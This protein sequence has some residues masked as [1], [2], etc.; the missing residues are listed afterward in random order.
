MLIIPKKVAGHPTPILLYLILF[1]WYL[2]YPSITV[3][4]DTMSFDKKSSKGNFHGLRAEKSTQNIFI[5]IFLTGDM[6]FDE[7]I[8]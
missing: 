1:K 5:D 4:T 6:K 8:I 2:Q 3:G 7:K